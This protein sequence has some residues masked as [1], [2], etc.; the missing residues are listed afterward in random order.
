MT[1]IRVGPSSISGRGIFAEV[2]FSS[3]DIVER[4]EVL[5][6]PASQ[7]DAIQQTELRAYLFSCDDG[8][9]DVA[10][11]LGLGSLYNHSDDANATYFKDAKHN[12]IVITAQRDI[13]AGEE[14]TVAYLRSW[15]MDGR[16]PGSE[17][18]GP[19]RGPQPASTLSS[20]PANVPRRHTWWPQGLRGSSRR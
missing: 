8:S 4:C 16:R 18:R 5:R 19:Y 7:V 3:G 6:I 1:G 12:V 11:A 10:I 20:G 2:P 13:A 17:E 14:I 15:L 9:G